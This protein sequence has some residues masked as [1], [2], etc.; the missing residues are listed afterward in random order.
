MVAELQQAALIIQ[1]E[2]IIVNSLILKDI[3]RYTCDVFKNRADRLNCQHGE[4]RRDSGSR[5]LN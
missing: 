1:C 5:A 3:K 2:H 4:L